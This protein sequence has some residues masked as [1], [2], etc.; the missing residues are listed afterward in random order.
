MGNRSVITLVLLDS[1]DNPIVGRTVDIKWV[2]GTFVNVTDEKGYVCASILFN[3]TGIYPIS[4]SFNGDE[5]YLPSSAVFNVKVKN[6]ISA[7]V[8]IKKLYNDVTVDILLSEKINS[9]LK[10]L[11]N[12]KEYDVNVVDGKASLKL[13][14]LKKNEYK[15]S[16]I[17]NDDVYTL[18]SSSHVSDFKVTEQDIASRNSHSKT[19]KIKLALKKVKVKKSAKKL[20]LKATLKINGKLAK[21][22][23][24]TFKFNK[25]TYRAKT[26]KKG[27][28]KI[29]IK[30]S[31]L[32]KLKVGKKVKYQV[33]YGKTTV[34]KTV[35]VKK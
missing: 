26:N 22:K 18:E 9:S 16:L 1:N 3:N 15:I 8:S 4:V 32:K 19:Q 11:I 23:K 28:A 7:N 2:N 34:K 25:K 13:N 29:I 6:L 20:V 14:G 17:L 27:V 10:V 33:S 30:K 12:D 35:K 5:L 24:V 31:V 21:G